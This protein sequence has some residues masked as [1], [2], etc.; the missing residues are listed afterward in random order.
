MP[1]SFFSLV[2]SN[3]SDI[4]ITESDEQTELP[5]ELVRIDA[6]SQTGELHFKAPSLLLSTTTTFYLYYGSSTA[7]AYADTD[8]YGRDNVWT[9]DYRAVYHFDLAEGGTGQANTYT[10]S[11]GNGNHGDDQITATGKSGIVGRG[12]QFDP[13]SVDYIPIPNNTINGISDI[14]T[15]VWY[16]STD[17]NQFHPFLSA[18]NAGQSNEY[19]FW[20][21]GASDQ[22]ELFSHSVSG[23]E[24]FNITDVYDDSWNYFVMIKDNANSI[25]RF[26]LNG[27]EDNESPDAELVNPL[28]VAS[29]GLMIGQEQDC[30]GGCFDSNQALNGYLDEMRISDA[31]RSA[32]WIANSYRNQS[33][34]TSFYTIGSVQTN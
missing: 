34:P 8:T 23:K 24:I 30:V 13:S 22:V 11:S 17:N 25:A 29:G 32:G 18:A 33:N 6:G 4:R 9:N 5:Y 20:L 2:N 31:V 19:L 12:Q 15:A 28:N 21:D 1:A 27:S 3:G 26:Y 16:R 14:T 10:D 7:S